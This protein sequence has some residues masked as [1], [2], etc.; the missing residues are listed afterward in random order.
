MEGIS[1][2]ADPIPDHA[3][4]KHA[5][6]QGQVSNH[7]F[8]VAGFPAKTLHLVT[9]GGPCGIARKTPLASFQESLRPTVVEAFGNSLPAAKPGDTLELAREI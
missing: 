4:F 7:L 6:F 5:V 1:F 3:F 2:V 8:E 9:G